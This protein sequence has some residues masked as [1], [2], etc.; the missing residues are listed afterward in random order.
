MR[1]KATKLGFYGG[2]RQPGDEFDVP[3]GLKGSWFEPVVVAE[4]AP[5]PE[6][7]EQSD[8]KAGEKKA[9]EGASNDAEQL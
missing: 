8:T 5:Q 6:E 1:V 7:S 9:A 3:E 2:R 4:P